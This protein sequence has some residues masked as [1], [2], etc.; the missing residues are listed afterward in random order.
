MYYAHYLHVRLPKI[1]GDKVRTT[2][3][4]FINI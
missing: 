3:Q 4:L 1:T 2:E